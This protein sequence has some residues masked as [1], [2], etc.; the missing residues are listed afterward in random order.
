MRQLH[1][2]AQT[3]P[4]IVGCRARFFSSDEGRSQS[5]DMGIH[6]QYAGRGVRVEAVG[7][8]PMPRVGNAH[9]KTTPSRLEGDSEFVRGN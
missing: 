6:N 1:N 3:G 4:E 9:A 7:R 2:P 8:A 5:F